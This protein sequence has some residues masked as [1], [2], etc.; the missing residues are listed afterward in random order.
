MP[1]VFAATEEQFINTTIRYRTYEQ[2]NSSFINI[3]SI[4]GGDSVAIDCNE[5]Q[6]SSMVIGFLRPILCPET[7]AEQCNREFTNLTKYMQ[8]IAEYNNDTV[9]FLPLYV[10]CSQTLFDLNATYN[11]IKEDQGYK[12]QYDSCVDL[13]KD[14]ESREKICQTNLLTSQDEANKKQEWGF[15]GVAIGS[16]AVWLILRIQKPKPK[17]ADM[18][19]TRGE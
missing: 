1:F 3:T 9:N 10:E 16:I 4:D 2:D 12:A 18:S 13:R 11:T 15:W 5:S 14:V 19:R 6:D 17:I 8:D 7:E